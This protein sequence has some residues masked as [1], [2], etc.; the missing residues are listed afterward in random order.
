MAV[1]LEELVWSL[2]GSAPAATHHKLV[3]LAA[4]SVSTPRLSPIRGATRASVSRRR[5]VQVSAM[6][7]LDFLFRGVAAGKGCE[8]APKTAAPGLEL[9]TFAGGW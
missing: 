1:T 3:M 8:L 6:G 4:R 2:R 5:A 7:L 9:A